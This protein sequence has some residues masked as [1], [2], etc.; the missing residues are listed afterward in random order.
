MTVIEEVRETFRNVPKGSE[1]TTSQ[2]K[3]MV[4]KKFGRTYGSVIP[5]DYC[6]NMTNKG[7]IGSLENFNIFIQKRRGLFEYVGENYR[8]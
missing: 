5:S 8:Y 6:Y 1:F 2:I 4:N 3:E 7:K